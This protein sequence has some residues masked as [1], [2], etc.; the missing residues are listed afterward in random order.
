MINYLTTSPKPRIL[1]TDATYNEMQCLKKHFGGEIHSLSPLKKPTSKFPIV[2]YGLHNLRA[3]KK[4]EKQASCHQIFAPALFH[5]PVVYSFSKP[6]IYN[7]VA[8]LNTDLKLPRAKFLSKIKVFI[9]SNIQDQQ[10]LK[11]KGI[12]NV[13]V[14]RTGIDVSPFSKNV[15][16]L[17][18]KIR[19]L[20][21]SAPWE[22]KQFRSKGIHLIF[23]SLQQ[24]DNIHL[25]LLWRN[26]LPQ[27]LEKLIKEY[28]LESK[29]SFVNQHV[30]VNEYIKK[31]H[32]TILLTN[33]R[34]LVK[35]YPHSLIESL[36]AGKP[37]ITT[38]NIP[39][40]AECHEQKCGLVLDEFTP[41]SLIKIIAKFRNQYK[42]LS[43]AA[44]ELDENY[45]SY[46]RF[47]DD[48]ESMLKKHNL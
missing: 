24:I 33:D 22:Q 5:L 2:L 14:I 44:Y 40:S 9:V 6:I 37:I 8:G 1:G 34:T 21:A 26:I 31:V 11:S 13:E 25:T 10:I 45:F 41:N 18:K 30:K 32:G 42:E 23:K 38:S 35:A 39:I 47:K 29:V 4:S 15:L 36:V 48:Y 7:V 27:H 3:I 17:D 16:K 28:N 19:L 43:K 46:E 12:E 20:L